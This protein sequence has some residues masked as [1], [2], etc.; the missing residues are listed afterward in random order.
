M[1]F[2]S[3]LFSAVNLGMWILIFYATWIMA[4]K[5]YVSMR[6]VMKKTRAEKTSDTNSQVPPPSK[7]DQPD[8]LY[9]EQVSSPPHKEEYR[10]LPVANQWPQQ[11]SNL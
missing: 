3:M 10:R 4:K 8:N 5:I 9:T 6:N 2:G 7:P 1:S 11:I